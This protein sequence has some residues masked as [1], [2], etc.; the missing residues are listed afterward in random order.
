M[1]P[2]HMIDAI[3]SCALPNRTPRD[4]ASPQLRELHVMQG[5][6]FAQILLY[7]FT[8]VCTSPRLCGIKRL[9]AVIAH[10][11][12]IKLISGHECK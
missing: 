8:T 6:M 11:I 10:F 5:N 2:Y 9:P 1:C 7:M 4:R 12:H 3:L